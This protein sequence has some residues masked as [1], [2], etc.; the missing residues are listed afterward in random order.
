MPNIYS[1]MSRR[2]LKYSVMKQSFSPDNLFKSVRQWIQEGY[3]DKT[4]FMEELSN[5]Q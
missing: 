5:V 3:W 1:S 4:L 2:S